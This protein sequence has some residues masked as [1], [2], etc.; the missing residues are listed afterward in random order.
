LRVQR[1]VFSDCAGGCDEGF[2]FP[3]PNSDLFSVPTPRTLQGYG[4]F[5]GAWE[6]WCDVNYYTGKD[7][8]SDRNSNNAKCK[9]C[10]PLPFGP[11][12][13]PDPKTMGGRA[14]RSLPQQTDLER[15][16]PPGGEVVVI[17]DAGDGG[18][19]GGSWFDQNKT[20]VL[21]GGVAAVALLAFGMRKGRRMNG[22]AGLFGFGSRKVRRRKARRN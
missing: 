11:C 4:A 13:Y 1:F 12:L 16:G 6:D 19:S 20:L 21:A 5:G 7:D 9:K 17:P 14:I 15:L 22:L 3:V 2:G 18:G 8:P 10:T